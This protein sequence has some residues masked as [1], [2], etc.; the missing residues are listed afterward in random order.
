MAAC[1]WARWR[2]GLFIIGKNW[3][4]ARSLQDD[5]LKQHLVFAIA[6]DAEGQIWV[7]TEVGLR[8]YSADLKPK[9][10]SAVLWMK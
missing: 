9:G 5:S 1:G 10:D 8:C 7:G 6:E 4:D 2:K 3:Q